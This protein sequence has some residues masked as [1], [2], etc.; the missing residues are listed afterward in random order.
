MARIAAVLKRTMKKESTDTIFQHKGVI[1]NPMAAQLE[2]G[3]K[4]AELTRNELKIMGV[5]FEHKGE[6][7]SRSALIDRLWDQEIYIDDNTLSV[8]VTRIRNKL[9]E[10]GLD[11]FIESKRGLGYKI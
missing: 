9:T 8:N 5:L 4:K 11:G 3:N 7:V 2:Y 6:F 10:M 1:L